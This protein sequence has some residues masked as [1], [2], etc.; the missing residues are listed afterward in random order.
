MSHVTRT[1]E[2]QL[3]AETVAPQWNQE[4]RLLLSFSSATCYS[5]LQDNCRTL[6][7]KGK[8]EGRAKS[9]REMTTEFVSFSQ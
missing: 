7:L 9:K 4:P 3:R 8:E 1:Q 6:G 5:W 2:V